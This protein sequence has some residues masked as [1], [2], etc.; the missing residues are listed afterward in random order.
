MIGAQSGLGF[1]IVD[2]RNALRLDLV[3]AGIIIIGVCGLMLD[4]LISPLRENNKS[5]TNIFKEEFKMALFL[6]EA[7]L[8][9]TLT[10]KE[11][12]QQKIEEYQAELSKNN[13]DF[14]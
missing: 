2:G 7:N 13:I 3:L 14:V 8:D 12:V 10:T 4:K 6:V 11:A 5:L 9:K 1:L